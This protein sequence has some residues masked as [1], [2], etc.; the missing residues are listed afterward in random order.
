MENLITSRTG[1]TTAIDLTLLIR[2]R[3]RESIKEILF[4][5]LAIALGAEKSERT[6]ER[7]GYRNGAGKRRL[8]T[9]LGPLTIT[10]LRVRCFSPWR[11]PAASP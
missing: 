7:K 11:L 4:E 2:H 10:V 5:E 9:E 6:D 8:V 1:K 3:I